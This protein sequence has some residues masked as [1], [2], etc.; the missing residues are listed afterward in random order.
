MKFR[1][2]TLAL[3]T[4]AGLLLA[5]DPATDNSDRTE[6][7][8]ETFDFDQRAGVFHFERDVKVVNPGIMT[9]TC[10]DLVAQM[11][12]RGVKRAPSEAGGV[13][14]ITANLDVR[15]QFI[16]DGATNYASGDRAIYT[17]TNSLLVLTGKPGGPFPQLLRDDMSITAE[18]ITLDLANGKSKFTGG[19]NGKP[20]FRASLGAFNKLDP[21]NTK[22][23]NAPAAKQP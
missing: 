9:L 4:S 8:S 23:T 7:T 6:I 19:P 20:L 12:A 3:A 16:S 10:G 22:R 21:F 14:K 13:D 18:N 5:A 1:A 11:P 17:K 2:L 15:I